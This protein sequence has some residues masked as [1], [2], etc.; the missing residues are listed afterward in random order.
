MWEEKQ[1]EDRTLAAAGERHAVT[2]V[3]A[4]RVRPG[5]SQSEVVLHACSE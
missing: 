4:H 5:Q 1:L 3:N 2:A